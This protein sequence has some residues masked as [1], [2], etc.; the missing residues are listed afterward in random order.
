[1]EAKS[2]SYPIDGPEHLRSFLDDAGFPLAEW[3]E[4][5]TKTYQEL[6][7]EL[8]D[9]E[10]EL[11]CPETFEARDEYGEIVRQTNVL[12]IDI[13]AEI[14]DEL[15]RLREDKQ[16]FKDGRGER[17]RNLITSIAEK[18][19]QD[20]DHDEAVV[21]AVAEEL[22]VTNILQAEE[23]EATELWQT[24]ATYP[25]LPSKLNIYKYSVTIAPEDFRPEG[26]MEDQPT[27]QNFFVWDKA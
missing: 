4:G 2:Y 8:A 17:R 23:G 21:R 26:Y 16:V 19:K 24:T 11:I 10:S 18:I 25:Q 7:Q 15:Y 5:P 27:K 3:G 9:G 20:E 6:W 14:D 13:F 22:G 12:G 1:M